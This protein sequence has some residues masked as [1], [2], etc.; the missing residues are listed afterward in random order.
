MFLKSFDQKKA[1]NDPLIKNLAKY[2]NPGSIESIRNSIDEAHK[3]DTDFVTALEHGM[4]PAGGLGIGIDRLVMLV[5]NAQ[6]IRDVIAFPT[7]RPV[8]K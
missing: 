4:P 8:T 6:S 3:M 1:K 2:C 5:T 7:M